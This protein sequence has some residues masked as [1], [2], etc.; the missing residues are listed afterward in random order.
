MSE[1]IEEWRPVVGFEGEYEVSNLGGVR[2]LARLMWNGNSWWMSKDRL[3]KPGMMT[4]GYW[5][6]FLHGGLRK[7]KSA[8]VHRLVAAAFIGESKME[9]NHK[10]GIKTDN[11]DCNLEYVTRTENVRHAFASGLVK[12]RNDVSGEK[13]PS[14]KISHG[15]AMKVIELLWLGLSVRE[16]RELTGYAYDIVANIAKKRTWKHLPRELK[17]QPIALTPLVNS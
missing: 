3:L 10:N 15:E 4:S 17:W 6:V 9:V 14:A 5:M 1:E 16:I 7:K 11:R 8:S 13:N 12:T 2:S